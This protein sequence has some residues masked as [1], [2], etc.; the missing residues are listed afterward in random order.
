MRKWPGSEE[1]TET[2][3]NLPQ[4]HDTAWLD[5][6]K[7]DKE[8]AETYSLALVAH[9]GSDGYLLGKAVKGHPWEKLPDATTVVDARS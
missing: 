5:L 7:Q 2:G 4:G 9:G 8:F 3:V 6:L 1:P